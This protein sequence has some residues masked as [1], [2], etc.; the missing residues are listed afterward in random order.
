MCKIFPNTKLTL[1]KA[2]SPGLVVMGDNSCL[3]GCV[4]ESWRHILDGLFSH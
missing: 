3:R 2:G 1:K 4:F